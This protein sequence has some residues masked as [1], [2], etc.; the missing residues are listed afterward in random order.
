MDL[1]LQPT[2]TGELLSL[3]PLRAD[4]FPALHAAAADPLVWEQHPEPDRHREDVFRRFFDGAIASKGALVATALA[5]GTVIGSSRYYRYDPAASEVTVGYTFL[6][7]A[8]W[9]GA[10]NG[11]MKR[12]MLA[13]AFRA[14]E[15]VRFE[16]GASN[17]RSQQALRKIGARLVRTVV[18]QGPDGTARSHLVFAISR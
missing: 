17:L 11:E 10:Y 14:V 5:S 2:L 3:R 6:A 16:V 15:R 18:T 4:D 12:L 1:D 7:R 8:F 13:H 9:G